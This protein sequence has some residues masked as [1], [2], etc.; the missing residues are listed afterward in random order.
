MLNS[1]VNRSPISRATRVAVTILLLVV[2]AGIAAAQNTFHT[3]AGTVVDATGRSIPGVTLVMTNQQ[4][5]SKYE[6]KTSREGRFEFVGLL[7]GDYILEAVYMGFKPYKEEVQLTGR[8]QQRQVALQIGELEE[9]ITVTISEKDTSAPVVKEVPMPD[10]VSGCRAIAVGGNIRAPKKVKDVRPEY[11]EQ[12]RGSGTEGLV[13]LT[14]RIGLDGYIDNI[15]TVGDAQADLVNA[16][17]AAVREW[18]FTQTLLNCT[19][20]EVPL[21]MTIHFRATPTS[22][23]AR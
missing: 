1:R 16:A 19:P 10:V 15:Q 23:A 14:G 7:P 12:L 11:P 9:T 13:L 18:R 20:V 5:E 21:K 6:V 22:P 17:I 2:T 8:D 3:L 4:R